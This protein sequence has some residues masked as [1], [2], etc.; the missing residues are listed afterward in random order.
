MPLLPIFFHSFK[1]YFGISKGL[2]F[3]SSTFLTSLISSTPR[4]FP[5]EEALPDL[6]GDPYPI[7]VL[8]EITVGFFVF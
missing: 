3:Q 4:G 7:L 8:Q 1:I 6:L 2:Y 5:C